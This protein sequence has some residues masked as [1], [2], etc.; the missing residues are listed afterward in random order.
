MKHVQLNLIEL[1]RTEAMELSD[2]A[3]VLVFNPFTRMYRIENADNNF[4]ARNKFVVPSL[5]YFL[6]NVG[7][8]PQK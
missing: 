8:L 7:E 2:N 1:T 5:R 4:S 3:Q 6:F